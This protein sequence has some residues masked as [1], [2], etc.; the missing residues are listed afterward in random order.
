MN[1]YVQKGESLDNPSQAL[2]TVLTPREMEILGVLASG[3][4]NEEIADKLF[5][6]PHTVKT[7]LYAIYRKINVSNRLQAVLWASKNL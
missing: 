4:K 2:E 5:I 6:S 3:A 1:E 7:H